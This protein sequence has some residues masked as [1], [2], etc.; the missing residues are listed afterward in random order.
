MLIFARCFA[1]SSVLG[2]HHPGYHAGVGPQLTAA[3]TC[4]KISVFDRNIKCYVMLCGL[5]S[6][7]KNW[8]ESGKGWD[9]IIPVILACAQ[10]IACSINMP[11]NNMQTGS[12]D[13]Q[14]HDCD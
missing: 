4:S 11:K 2:L 7:L 6:G 8:V 5:R 14:E 13:C 3:N 9:S 1:N 10:A 12:A